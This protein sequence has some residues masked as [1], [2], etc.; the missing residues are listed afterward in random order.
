M[1]VGPGPH[2]PQVVVIMLHAL[3]DLLKRVWL[4]LLGRDFE[5]PRPAP[6]FHT[7]PGAPSPMVSPPPPPQ[8]APA[9]PL[10]P[11]I[12]SPQP[13]EPELGLGSNEPPAYRRKKR[14][15]SFQERR[16]YRTLQQEVG[17]EYEVLA[18]VRIGD[19]I[20]LANE[21]YDRKRY[22]TLLWGRHFDF[23]VCDRFSML[24]L[25]AI[26]LD[27]SSHTRYDRQ[28][29]DA[30]KTW[31]CEQSGL[32]LLRF[33]AEVKYTQDTIGRAVRQRLQTSDNDPGALS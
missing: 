25:L 27:D 26:E 31:L 16:F 22:S 15:L 5:T 6:P 3:F 4:W 20:E 14:L 17:Q 21:P 32:P 33:Q 19:V 24:P 7:P 30:V 12:T 9:Q 28:K 1:V 13:G 10:P 8:P 18:K 2:W 23:L 29:S 11:A